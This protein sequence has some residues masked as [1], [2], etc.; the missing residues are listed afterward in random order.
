[1]HVFIITVSKLVMIIMNISAVNTKNVPNDSI[2]TEM[3]TRMLLS[4][5]AVGCF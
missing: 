5:V 1:M 3:C 2:I 4:V